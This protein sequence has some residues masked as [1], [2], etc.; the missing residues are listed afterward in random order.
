MTLTEKILDEILNYLDNSIS[1]L[2]KLSVNSPEFQQD[3]KSLNHFLS[4]QYEIRLENLLQKKNIDIHHLESGIKNK[5]IQ[6]KQKQIELIIN[7]IQ[8]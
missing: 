4:S 2:A 8:N 5:I 3:L 6:R 7:E 1:N